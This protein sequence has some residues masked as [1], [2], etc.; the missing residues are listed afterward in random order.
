MEEHQEE[1]K[2]INKVY[3]GV[4]ASLMMCEQPYYIASS[5]KAIRVSKLATDVLKLKGF[6]Q[7]SPR[8][9]A[10]LLPPSEKKAETLRCAHSSFR[11]SLT[12]VDN[13]LG[14]VLEVQIQ[15]AI[16]FGELRPTYTCYDMCPS[17]QA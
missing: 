10:G 12:P 9:F 8:L 5:K 4:A 2:A 11:P 14:F 13:P 15:R 3:P 6:E 7:D 1:Y 17:G 16:A